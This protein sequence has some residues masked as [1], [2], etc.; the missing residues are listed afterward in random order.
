M[1]WIP[2]TTRK[3]SENQF[4]Q[5]GSRSLSNFVSWLTTNHIHVLE[6]FSLQTMRNCLC[7]CVCV[8]V[9]I[10]QDVK[11]FL[12]IA[13]FVLRSWRVQDYW[14]KPMKQPAFFEKFQWWIAR[15]AMGTP[16]FGMW[17]PSMGRTLIPLSWGRDGWGQTLGNGD[18]NQA[19]DGGDDDDDDDD[20]DGGDGNNGTCFAL[21]QGKK[22]ET[23]WWFFVWCDSTPRE[24]LE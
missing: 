17:W 6:M 8:C 21:S 7:L 18:D 11:L 16:T 2:N 14:W 20:D 23:T 3:V 10:N 4:S 12:L 1:T 13:N 15:M 19:G 24:L 5:S 22:C 9:S